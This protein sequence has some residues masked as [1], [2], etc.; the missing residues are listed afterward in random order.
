MNKPTCKCGFVFNLLIKLGVC[1]V[2]L[3]V[4]PY[5]FLFPNVISF[6]QSHTHW[7]FPAIFLLRHSNI[8]RKDPPLSFLLLFFS[9]VF[10]ADCMNEMNWI[11]CDEQFRRWDFWLMKFDYGLVINDNRCVCVRAWVSHPRTPLKD[12]MGEKGTRIETVW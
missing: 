11:D 1:R 2:Y 4:I 5:F 7:R 8:G 9:V 6:S 12:L 10:P 3:E